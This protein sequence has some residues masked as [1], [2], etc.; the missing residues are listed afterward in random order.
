MREEWRTSPA[1]IW[2]ARNTT[3]IAERHSKA[4]KN[5][6]SNEKHTQRSRFSP[7]MPRTS[8]P[9]HNC[10]NGLF[11]HKMPL[12]F[13]YTMVQKKS[14]MTKNSNQGGP[15]LILLVRWVQSSSGQWVLYVLV[16][17]ATGGKYGVGWQKKIMWNSSIAIQQSESTTVFFFWILAE[18]YAETPWLSK[19]PSITRFEC[20]NKQN[21]PFV[22]VK[23][24][25]AL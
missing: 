14:K 21:L 1:S 10:A 11:S 6:S 25:S 22:L 5:E 12:Y 8:F 17:M 15:A 2:K 13:F 23:L 24:T 7:A 9:G 19:S 3:V 4:E 20:R 18:E 16:T